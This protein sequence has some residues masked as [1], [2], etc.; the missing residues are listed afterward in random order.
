MGC[1]MTAKNLYYLLATGIVACMFFAVIPAYAA[2]TPETYS[3]YL[4]Q[5]QKAMQTLT[6]N[7]NGQ[8]TLTGPCQRWGFFMQ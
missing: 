7:C 8:V 1:V 5:G 4:Y 3:N 6:L 2:S